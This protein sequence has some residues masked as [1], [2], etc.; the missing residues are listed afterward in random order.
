MAGAADD[1]V[2]GQSDPTDPNSTYS[3]IQLTAEGT[4]GRYIRMFVDGVFNDQHLLTANETEHTFELD[5]C[6]RTV[7]SDDATE[8]C[9]DWVGTVDTFPA[10]TLTFSGMPD[11]S[12]QTPQSAPLIVGDFD[13][14]GQVSITD[15]SLLIASILDTTSVDGQYDLDSDND[16]DSIDLEI[17]INLVLRTYLGD[18]NLDG[19]FNSADLVVVFGAGEYEDTTT[20]NSLWDEGDWNGD[21]EF[22]SADFIV[23]FAEGAYIQT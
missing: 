9:T 14:D 17:F 18:A 20:G 13:Y 4:P 12:D 11:G 1:I 10:I 15:I 5:I 8:G 2:A 22:D 6:G 3:K 7:A 16:N 21:G 23:A 19:I